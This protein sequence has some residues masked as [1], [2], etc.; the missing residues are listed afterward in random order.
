MEIP[1][2]ALGQRT[3]FAEV[4]VETFVSTRGLERVTSE[5]CHATATASKG[6]YPVVPEVVIK[7]IQSYFKNAHI[8]ETQHHDQRGRGKPSGFY[9]V[10][11][12]KHVINTGWS[13]VQRHGI[14][15]FD[16]SSSGESWNGHGQELI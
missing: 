6:H 16:G 8:F 4:Q 3:R 14:Q 11:H 1:E 12:V 13:F 5:A 2:Y 9:D 10:K 7:F 15:C